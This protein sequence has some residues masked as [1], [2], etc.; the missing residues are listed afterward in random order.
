MRPKLTVLTCVYNG[1]PYLKEAIESTLNQTYKNFEYLIIDDCSPDKQVIDLIESYDDD[2]IRF[3]KN[4]INLGV[5][6]TIN[7]ALSLIDTTYVIRLDQDDVSLPTRLESQLRYLEEHP[8]VDVICSWEHEIDRF[9]NKK[10]D[11]KRTLDNYGDFL[12]Y[13]LIGLCPIWHPSLAFKKDVLVDA[14][15]FKTEYTRAEDFEV[16]ARLALQRYNASI[17]PEFLL[18][19]RKHDESQSQEFDS[20]QAVMAKRIHLE[21]LEYFSNHPDINIL[22]S[23]LRLEPLSEGLK[24]DQHNFSRLGSALDDLYSRIT[25]KQDLTVDELKALKKIIN[26]RV[27]Y[28]INNY[29]FLV[30]LPSFLFFPA[31]YACSPLQ[32][33]KL[34]SV[35]AHVY[36]K[37]FSLRYMFSKG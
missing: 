20:V 16:T 13:I 10:W 35:V 15:G 32:F 1:L 26:K 18:L 27:G 22:A 23:Y 19:Q 2:R 28:S 12:G 4:E 34:K 14:G 21:A 3:I 37:I 30:S 5:S 33:N 25:I 6:K 7:K 17:V 8:E 9:G 24:F 11:W 31:Y 29:K 36:H